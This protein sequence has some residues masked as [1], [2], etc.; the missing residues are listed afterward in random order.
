MNRCR[1]LIIALMVCGFRCPLVAQDGPPPAASLQVIQLEIVM[2]T[3]IMP[4]A[5]STVASEAENNS[6]GEVMLSRIEEWSKAGYLASSTRVRLT[7]VSGRPAE[8]EFREGIWGTI[9]RNV[10]R[11]LAPASALQ[12]VLSREDLLTTATAT[13]TVQADGTINVV[14]SAEQ[15]RQEAPGTRASPPATGDGPARPSKDLYAAQT[16]VS[17]KPWK[18]TCIGGSVTESQGFA[19]HNVIIITARIE[20]P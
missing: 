11:D 6:A 5:E 9:G 2:A 20:E 12:P 16:R 7:T 17:L 3:A 4:K 8:F 18:S 10:A 14:I 19:T 13:P 1:M 15:S